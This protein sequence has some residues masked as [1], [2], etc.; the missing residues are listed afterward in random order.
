M[1]Q[2]ISCYSLSIPTWL[3]SLTEISFNTSHVTLYRYSLPDCSGEER[4]QYISCYSL[5]YAA[6]LPNKIFKMFQYISCYSLSEKIQSNQKR[7]DLFQYISCYSLSEAK[8]IEDKDNNGFNTSHVTLYQGS[9]Q[10][11]QYSRLVSIHLMLLFIDCSRGLNRRTIDVSIH[12]M[13]LFIEVDQ[14]IENPELTF[15]YISCYS[16]SGDHGDGT[17]NLVGFNT[18]HVTLYLL[19]IFR[20][21]ILADR[22]NTS[23]VTLYRRA[24]R[25][26]FFRKCRFNTSH[27]TLYR[28]HRVLV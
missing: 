9:A 7:C 17:A 27:V 18:S 19:L 3:R 25:V 11:V 8:Y 5:S 24:G 2:Y 12:L 13:L 14:V 15:Q 23:H 16:L 21:A 1:F 20:N 10:G 28:L 4:F 6:L 22:F 26:A